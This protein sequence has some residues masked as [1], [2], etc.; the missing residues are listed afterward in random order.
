MKKDYASEVSGDNPVQEYQF[1]ESSKVG[2]FN[3]TD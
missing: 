1:R 2:R 3:P